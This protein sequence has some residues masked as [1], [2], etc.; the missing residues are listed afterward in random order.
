MIVEN[1]L[2]RL[3]T[4]ADNTAMEAE[5]PK[6]DPRKQK[7]R[8]RPRLMR[9]LLGKNFFNVAEEAVLGG[10]GVDEAKA[11]RMTIR[12]PPVG[13]QSARPLGILGRPGPRPFRG[14]ANCCSA[15]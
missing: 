1:P 13:R 2:L 6:L 3:P 9:S 15:P 10:F 4:V 12:R 8:R 5:S 7:R 11:D 14:Q